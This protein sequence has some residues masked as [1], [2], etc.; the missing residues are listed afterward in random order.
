MWSIFRSLPKFYPAVSWP[1]AGRCRGVL[2]V[3]LLLL[4]SMVGWIPPGESAEDNGQFQVKADA[5]ILGDLDSGVVLYQQN[6][7]QRHAPASLTKVMTLY[8][9]YE[10]L[11]N[12]HLNLEEQLPVSERAWRQGGSKTFVKVGDRVR[13]EEL[14][15]GIAVQSGND[16]C[17]VIAEHLA[18]SEEAFSDMMNNK[19]KELGMTQTHF[20][21]ASGLPDD[22]HYT[23]ARDLFL[24]ASAVVRDYPQYTHY[25]QE[26]QYTFGGIRQYNRN[27]LLWR[28]PSVTGLKT[29]HTQAA[30]YCM[31]ATNE[32]EGQRLGAVILGA[33]SSKVR[34]EEALRLL[35]YGN[36][37]FETVRFYEANKVVRKMRVWKG[38]TEHVDGITKRPLA[39]TIP[40]KDRGKLEVGLIY[41]DPLVAPIALGE[42]IGTLVVKMGGN[43]VVK[44]P[45]L[46]AAAVNEGG[47]VRSMVDS[48][49]LKLGW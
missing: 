39:V 41:K 36:R 23:S 2:G 26:K 19:A 34:E 43:E 6:A 44:R 21:N 49:R 9:T 46:A 42:E 33:P 16:A 8:L 31:I 22:N 24:L 35:R 4:L 40:R 37:N 14:I 7:E 48:V 32:V 18:G 10:A 13:L 3:A 20:V 1:A 38:E 12:N 28:D 47:I 30:G 25:S 17:V 27:R 29:G 5:A 11:A 45:L 15:Y